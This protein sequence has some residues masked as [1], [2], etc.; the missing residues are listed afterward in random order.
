MEEGAHFGSQCA[1]TKKH[2]TKPKDDI[3]FLKF[4]EY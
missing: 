2:I 4:M 3:F 1:K